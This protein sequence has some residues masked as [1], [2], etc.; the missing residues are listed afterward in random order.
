MCTDA[1][2]RM[3]EVYDELNNK[4]RANN[5]RKKATALFKKF[6]EAFWDG[7]FRLLTIRM[8]GEKNKVLSVASNVE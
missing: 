6:N 2:L 5:L 3:A 1:W 4:R 8:D 7:D